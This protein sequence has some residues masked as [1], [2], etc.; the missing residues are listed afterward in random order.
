MVLNLEHGQQHAARR[1]YLPGRCCRSM[2]WR[3]LP[4]PIWLPPPGGRKTR[5]GPVRSSGRPM[6]PAQYVE[7]EAFDDYWRGRPQ[8]DGI[9][10]RF[11]PEAGS[12]V[13]ALQAGDIAFTYMTLDEALGPR[14]RRG[15]HGPLRPVAGAQ[16]PGLR[17]DRPAIRGSARAPG[18]HV[19]HRP[20]DDRRAALWGAGDAGQLRV[21]PAAVCA[22]WSERLRP[23]RRDRHATALRCWVRHEP[24]G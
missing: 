4:L 14:R 23:E 3:T 12:S 16:L 20:P 18:V 21:H 11:F 10:N 6:R 2:R 1:I 8:L 13:I 24:A 15:L 19:R 5:S 22:G 9:I 7:L 17:P